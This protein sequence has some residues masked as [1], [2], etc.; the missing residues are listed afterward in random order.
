M[1]QMTASQSPLCCDFGEVTQARKGLGELLRRYW[2]RHKSRQ[3]L[4]ALTDYQLR[5][6]GLTRDQVVREAIKPFWR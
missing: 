3:Q 6:L 1:T 5:D 4:F 2:Q